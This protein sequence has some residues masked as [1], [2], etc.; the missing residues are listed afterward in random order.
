MS[1]EGYDWKDRQ[2]RR[3]QQRYSWMGLV[4]ALACLLCVGLM[5]ADAASD[6]ASHS[7][8][9]TEQIRQCLNE[10]R[11]AVTTNHGVTCV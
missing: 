3:P 9:Q 5:L 6:W 8:R 1:L 7:E 4:I 2:R 10:G 11:Y